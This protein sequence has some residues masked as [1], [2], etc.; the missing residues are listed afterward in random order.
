MGQAVKAVVQPVDINDACDEL[1]DELSVWLRSRLAHYKCPRSISFEA[2]LPR[3][4]SGKLHKNDLVK[5]Y[6]SDRLS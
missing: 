4:E 2:R 3:S 1:G 5:R 6:S